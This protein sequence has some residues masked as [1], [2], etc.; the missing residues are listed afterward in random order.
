MKEF[1]DWRKFHIPCLACHMNIAGIWSFLAVLLLFGPL[2]AS[3]SNTEIKCPKEEKLEKIY[4][5][6]SITGD[7]F[8]DIPIVLAMLIGMLIFMMY[9][10]ADSQSPN[11][12]ELHCAV[13]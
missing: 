5:G 11:S 7:I 3:Q 8:L 13:R 10:L 4:D 1:L 6:N 9:V 2:N 12:C